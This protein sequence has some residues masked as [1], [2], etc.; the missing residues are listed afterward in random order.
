M[1]Y[2]ADS[3]LLNSRVLQLLGKQVGSGDPLTLTSNDTDQGA[4]PCAV[5]P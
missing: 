5:V 3:T 1:L 2:R 4:L